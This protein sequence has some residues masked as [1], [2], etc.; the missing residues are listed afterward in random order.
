MPP[1]LN[2]TVARC[3]DNTFDT[4]RWYQ[5][6]YK[7][8][9]P[10]LFLSRQSYATR[11]VQVLVE[12]HL[13]PPFGVDGVKYLQRSLSAA[14]P[15]VKAGPGSCAVVGNAG[16]L[17]GSKSGAHIDAHDYVIRMNAAIVR[18]YEAD[19]GSKTNLTLFNPEW[20]NNIE[21]HDNPYIFWTAKPSGY[22]WLE[23]AFTHQ[24]LLP[25][26]KMN[27]NKPISDWSET[28]FPEGK[29][30]P[31]RGHGVAVLHP[32]FINY[33]HHVWNEGK[34]VRPSTGQLALMLALHLCDGNVSIYG[35]D[36]NTEYSN[37]Y[38]LLEDRSSYHD[39][40]TETAVRQ[41]LTLASKVSFP[42]VDRNSTLE[43]DLLE[44]YALTRAS[45]PR[46]G[47]ELDNHAR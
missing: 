13:R 4:E 22:Q 43:D 30:P 27:M 26:L 1:V 34:G 14:L 17:M 41:C 40:E 36:R 9:H 18:G 24:G 23:R 47:P 11:D 5:A 10:P 25:Y 33:V 21:D 3:D 35:F 46:V 42:D 45:R 7:A 37:Q 6:R 16:N 32:S 44:F 15:A 29:P 31:G 39:W 2:D 20:T 8:G 12:K 38:H 28:S 19:V